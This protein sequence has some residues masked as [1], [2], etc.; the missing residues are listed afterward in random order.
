MGTSLHVKRSDNI[1]QVRLAII[2][3]QSFSRDII[4][5]GAF[6][7]NKNGPLGI[8]CNDSPAPRAMSRA[9]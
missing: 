7:E 6:P 3:V 8:G 1:E 2:R 5:R 9:C 4:E